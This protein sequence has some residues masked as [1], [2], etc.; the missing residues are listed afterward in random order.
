MAQISKMYK[1]EMYFSKKILYTY[2]VSSNNIQYFVRNRQGK[3]HTAQTK[4]LCTT[5]SCQLNLADAKL[6]SLEMSTM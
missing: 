5:Y 2:I 4:N 1:F 6:E 3:E